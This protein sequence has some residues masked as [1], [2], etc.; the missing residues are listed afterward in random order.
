[1]LLKVCLKYT[2][3]KALLIKIILE[4][5]YDD[6][7][8]IKLNGL[9]VKEII[10]NW[11]HEMNKIFKTNYSYENVVKYIKVYWED[12]YATFKK[13]YY[14]IVNKTKN[15]KQYYGQSL[16]EKIHTDNKNLHLLF[17][18]QDN[19]EDIA[20]TEAHLHKI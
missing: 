20:W 5:K 1:M 14:T 7:Y 17:V 4:L 6:I 19:G 9:N 13:E 8:A 15:K 3:K 12:A 11:L 2:F 10:I 18:P 16:K